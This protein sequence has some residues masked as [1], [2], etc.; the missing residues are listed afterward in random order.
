[1]N[2]FPQIN[3]FVVKLYDSKKFNNGNFI[4]VT[5]PFH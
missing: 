4:M 1:M 5:K 3:C 2:E